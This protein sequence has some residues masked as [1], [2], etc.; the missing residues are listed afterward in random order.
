MFIHREIKRIFYNCS[1]DNF[2]VRIKPSQVFIQ[3]S[4]L[5]LFEDSSKIVVTAESQGI[6]Q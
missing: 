4:K 2:I 1:F 3:H 5:I 6:P